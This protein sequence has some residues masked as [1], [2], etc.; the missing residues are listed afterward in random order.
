MAHGHATLQTRAA[1]KYDKVNVLPVT[2]DLK[3]LTAGTKAAIQAQTAEGVNTKEE[4]SSLTKQVLSRL[5]VFNKRRPTE[6]S[7]TTLSSWNQRDDCKQETDNEIK[8]SM[9]RLEQRLYGK[10]DLV[11]MRGK[12]GN[13]VPVLVPEHVSKA[14][15][16]LTSMRD[17]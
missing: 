14:L 2:E 10:M 13:R 6:V 16:V 4:F 7:K 12:C 11:M 1:K 17:K 9:G 8:Q 15:N 3:K 5:S